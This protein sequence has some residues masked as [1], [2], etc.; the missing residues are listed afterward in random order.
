[1]RQIDVVLY[2]NVSP[3][4]GLEVLY[5][6]LRICLQALPYVVLKGKKLD[7]LPSFATPSCI[8]SQM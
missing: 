7:T 1:M 4:S 2:C 8:G 5:G 6:E 3:T